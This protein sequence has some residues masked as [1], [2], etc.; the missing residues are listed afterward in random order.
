M[1]IESEGYKY[2]GIWGHEWNIAKKAV[3]KIQQ[4]WRKCNK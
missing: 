1:L 2:I 4:Q 3:K